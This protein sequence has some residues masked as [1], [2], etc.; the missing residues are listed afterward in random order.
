MAGLAG[1]AGP[2][3]AATH[4]GGQTVYN[5]ENAGYVASGRSFRFVST[6]LTVPPRILPKG[7]DGFVAIGIYASCPGQCAGPDD[8][9]FVQPG[10]GPGSV[11]YQSFGSVPACSRSARKPVTS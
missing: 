4:P 11:I 5:I 3:I 8:W 7:N 2:A 6:T 10:G 1:A 9:I